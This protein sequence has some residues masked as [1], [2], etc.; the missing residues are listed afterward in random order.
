LGRGS[1]SGTKVS[2]DSPQFGKDFTRA[3]SLAKGASIKIIREES[4][5]ILA[6]G[7]D[8]IR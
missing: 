1:G 2:F 6:P 7:K 8:R 3:V 4:S 5:T